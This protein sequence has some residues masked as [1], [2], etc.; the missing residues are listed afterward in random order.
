MPTPYPPPPNLYRTFFFEMKTLLSPHIAIVGSI[1]FDI[2]VHAPRVIK[3]GENLPV[4]GL[5]TFAGG[6]GANRA[7]AAKRLGARSTLIGVVGDDAFGSF[8]KTELTKNEVDLHYLKTDTH[9]ATGV[10]FITLFPSTNNAIMVDGGANFSLQPA[11]IEAAEI[12]I[13]HA[14]AVVVDLEVPLDVLA[15]T[16]TLARKHKKLSILDAGPARACPMELLRQF[17]I[18]SPNESEL[19][20]LSGMSVTDV[21]TAQKAGEYLLS[22]GVAE[23]IL[24]LSDQGSMWMKGREVK[25]FPAVSVSA[26]DPTAAGDAFT[27]AVAIQLAQKKSVDEACSYGNLVGALTTTKMGAMA[28]LP[29]LQEL[30]HFRKRTR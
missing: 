24:K 18:V 27:T 4:S 21:E 3:E 14:D 10:A 8:L 6:K 9:C 13:A 22:Q 17:D 11:D 7:V 15:A 20:K 16:C 5:K 26:I 2:V 30:E 29:T 19:E 23:L 28:S 12:A 25:H 1:N